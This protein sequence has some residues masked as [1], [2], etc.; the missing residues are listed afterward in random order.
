MRTRSLNMVFYLSIK[1]IKVAQ[2]S[3]LP[4]VIGS[5]HGFMDVWVL[6][7]IIMSDSE[8]ELV[9]T[10]ISP[11][12][13]QLKISLKVHNGF[14]DLFTPTPQLSLKNF[15]GLSTFRASIIPSMEKT[16]LA[17]NNPKSKL[18]LLKYHHPQDKYTIINDYDPKPQTF[19]TYNIFP[20]HAQ[21]QKLNSLREEVNQL[22]VYLRTEKEIAIARVK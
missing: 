10:D 1:P 7:F 3:S 17:D 4:S 22:E 11:V 21:Q 15:S 9:E 2:L 14:W 18:Q 16:M 5:E 13:E 12:G 6:I 8:L 20:N 19:Y